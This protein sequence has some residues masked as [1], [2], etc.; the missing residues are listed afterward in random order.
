MVPADSRRIPRVPRYSGYR[1]AAFRFTYWTTDLI[2]KD[3]IEGTWTQATFTG[4]TTQHFREELKSLENTEVHNLSF[5]WIDHVELFGVE[6]EFRVLRSFT[7][8]RI[9]DYDRVK[10]KVELLDDGESIKITFCAGD[11][12]RAIETLKIPEEFEKVS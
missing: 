11:D 6:L 10:K 9:M 12:N 3:Q 2:R 4:V 5:V 8:A 7:S 1:Y